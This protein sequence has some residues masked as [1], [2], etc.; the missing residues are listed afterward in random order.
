MEAEAT[1][2]QVR[3]LLRALDEVGARAPE[4][5]PSTEGMEERRLEREINDRRER[6]AE[7]RGRELQQELDRGDAHDTGRRTPK[8][9]VSSREDLA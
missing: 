8:P 9:L 6:L 4:L 2:R 7:L 1:L 5:V 3:D